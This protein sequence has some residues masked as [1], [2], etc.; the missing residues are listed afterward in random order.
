METLL[1]DGINWV[2]HVDWDI[3]DF[4][5]YR[6]E[7]GSTYNSYLV[8]DKKTALIDTVKAPFAGGLLTSI[9]SFVDPSKIDYVVCN[10][11]EPD[12]SGSLPGILEVCWNAEVVCDEKCRDALSAHY[13]TADWQWRIV[14]DGDSLPLGKKS[15]VFVETPMVH[16][17]ESMFTYV[18]EDKILFSMDAFGQ[19]YASAHRFDDQEPL[20]IIMAE[21]RTYYA[22][23]V[24]LYGRQ[25]AKVLNRA[26]ELDIEMIA[27]SHGVIWRKNLATILGAYKDWIICKPTAKVLV[28]YDTM[29]GSTELMANAIAEGALARDVDVRVFHA[30]RSH[31]TELATQMLDAAAVAFGSPTVNMTMMPAMASVLTHL[32][33]LRPTGKAGMAFGS[34]GW[35]QGAAKD[36]GDYLSAMKF[37]ILREPLLSHYVPDEALLDGCRAAGR[38]LAD[39]AQERA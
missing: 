16:W 10:H 36:I 30:R 23:I 34:Y 17:P 32:K 14:A 12:H 13:N 29:W 37:D 3:R 8:Q 11:A 1:R 38:L 26:A 9:T 22:N 18:P 25:I 33:G 4:H 19:H 31:I 27:P 24:M 35:G 5:G 39:E 15:L 2:G 28:I 20:D 7:K 6:T 21:A